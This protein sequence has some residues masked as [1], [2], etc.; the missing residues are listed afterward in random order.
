MFSVCLLR[1][2]DRV[3]VCSVFVEDGPE[4]DGGKVEIEAPIS[5][6]VV[7]LAIMPPSP[8][9]STELENLPC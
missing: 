5:M 7:P 4:E 1:I 6:I 9:P 3:V 8:S 2:R